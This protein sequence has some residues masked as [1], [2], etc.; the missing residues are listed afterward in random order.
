MEIRTIL[1]QID[2]DSMALPESR[3]G[4]VRDRDQVRGLMKSLDRKHPVGSLLVWET[5]AENARA[6]RRR[7][8]RGRRWTWR[9]RQ[10]NTTPLNGARPQIASSV[11][12][13]L[14]A[15]CGDVRLMREWDLS[16]HAADPVGRITTRRLRPW[17]TSR[18]ESEGVTGHPRPGRSHHTR[19]APTQCLRPRLSRP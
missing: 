19:S 16:V 18:G 2:L 1:D 8:S 12:A 7:A 9:E 13:S 14:Q 10:A 6:P 5:R 15:R 4:Y 3:R 11:S 17:T